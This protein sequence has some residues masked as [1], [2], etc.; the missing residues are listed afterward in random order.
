MQGTSFW[1]GVER[2]DKIDTE[3]LS[4]ECSEKE[5]RD[6]ETALYESSTERLELNTSDTHSACASVV[7]NISD[8]DRAK[9]VDQF[10]DIL[11][12]FTNET[13]KH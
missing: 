12:T 10:D 7:R 2:A 11:R 5:F 13:N 4:V 6:I 1:C 8:R 3:N 9:D